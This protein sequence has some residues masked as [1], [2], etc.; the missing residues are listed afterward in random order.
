MPASSHPLSFVRRAVVVAA[1]ALVAS[2]AAYAQKA[3]EAGHG[4]DGWARI[5]ELLRAKA[6]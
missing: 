6:A 2:G 5:I 4:T 3:V 1:A